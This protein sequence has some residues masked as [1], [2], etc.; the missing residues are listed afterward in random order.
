MKRLMVLHV[1][2]KTNGELVCIQIVKTSLNFQ[3]V[4]HDT[5][6]EIF[7]AFL[8]YLYTDHSPIEDG[9]SLGILELSDKYVTPRLMALCELYVSKVVEKATARSIAEADVD[10]VGKTVEADYMYRTLDSCVGGVGY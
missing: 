10:V 7:L 4:I 6:P 3:I 8:E 9:D 1:L 2:A 5:T